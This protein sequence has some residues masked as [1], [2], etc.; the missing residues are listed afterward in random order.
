LPSKSTVTA[1]T[2]MPR[3]STGEG[4]GVWSRCRSDAG[5]T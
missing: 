3:F 4:V 1:P 2:L 5:L